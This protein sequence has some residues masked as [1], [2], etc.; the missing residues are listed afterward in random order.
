MYLL[1]P[2]LD[3]AV[4]FYEPVAFS[5]SRCVKLL[6]NANEFGRSCFATRALVSSLRICQILTA[7]HYSA[8][9][10]DFNAA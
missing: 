2:L 9:N 3:V 1:L 8:D 10:T 4:A 5:L 6:G 7:V